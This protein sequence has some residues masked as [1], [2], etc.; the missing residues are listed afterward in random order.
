M[1]GDKTVRVGS[2]EYVI[3]E[4]DDGM[5]VGKLADSIQNAMNERTVITVP[6]L[7]QKRNRATLYLN[8]ATADAV[9]LDLDLPPRP[10]QMAP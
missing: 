8:G 4:N 6:V 2:F 10:G 9:V 7:N 5:D 1:D 3:D